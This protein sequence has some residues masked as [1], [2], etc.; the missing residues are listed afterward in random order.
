MHRCCGG[1]ACQAARKN[2]VRTLTCSALSSS[3]QWA[4]NSP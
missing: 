4:L 1:F 3:M 2:S